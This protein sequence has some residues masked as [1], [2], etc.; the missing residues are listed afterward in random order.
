M[1]NKRSYIYFLLC[2]LLTVTFCGKFN[3]VQAATYDDK[4][5]KLEVDNNKSWVI[6]FNKEL[7]NNTIDDSK[8]VVTD[9]GGQ[10]VAVKVTLG[11]DG[12]SVVVSPKSQYNYGKTYNLFIK[13]G[14]KSKSKNGL[15]KTA[16]MQ[17]TVKNSIRQMILIR[18]IQ[19]VLMQ[20]MVVVI[21]EVL[22]NQVQ[23][24]KM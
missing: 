14:I 3:F 20:V 8:F 2:F 15:I 24:K 10:Q 4:G 19:F 23:K 1:N 17:F 11:T 6:K 7:D 12:K 13:D 21:Q 9:E 16:K 22:D 5:I 18:L